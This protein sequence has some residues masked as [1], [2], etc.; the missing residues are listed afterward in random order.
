MKKQKGVTLTAMLIGCVILVFALLLVFKVI[1]VYAEYNT[2][3]KNFEA[4][5][6]DPA[7][8]K[9]PVSNMRASWENRTSVDNVK[10]LSGRDIVFDRDATGWTISADYSVKVPLF[11]NV[12]LYFD[13]H[14]TSN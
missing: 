2:I 13:F 3:K 7:L 5:A 12:S 1:P 9:A 8:Q 11:Q 14:P 10:S 4:M 6:R